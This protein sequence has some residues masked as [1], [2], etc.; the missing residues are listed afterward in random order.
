M[1]KVSFLQKSS[2]SRTDDPSPATLKDA[3]NYMSKNLID[4]DSELEPPQGVAQTDMQKGSLPATDVG[5]A[6]FDDVAPRKTTTMLSTSSTNSVEGPMLQIPNLASAPQ[7]RFSNTKS[8][9]FSPTNHGSQL[10]QHNFSP[11]NTVQYNDTLLNRATSAPVHSQVSI[12]LL[13][14]DTSFS[15]DRYLKIVPLHAFLA[16]ESCITYTNNTM[17][18]Y[19]SC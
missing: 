11:V 9:S 2:S 16:M 3:K 14:E 19:S 13:L 5:W 8:L 17:G 4:F 12:V 7:I 18:K 10:N 1:D 15:R 6:T